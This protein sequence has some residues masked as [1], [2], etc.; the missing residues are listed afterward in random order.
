M[1]NLKDDV[2]NDIMGQLSNTEF[3]YKCDECGA[4]IKV[5]LGKNICPK[6]HTVINVKL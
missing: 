1:T 2:M 5:K 3:D 4:N 6:C